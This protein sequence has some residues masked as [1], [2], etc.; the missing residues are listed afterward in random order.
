MLP[1]AWQVDESKVYNLDARLFCQFPHVVRCSR[2]E[3]RLLL[4]YRAVMVDGCSTSPRYRM[5][6]TRPRESLPARRTPDR[7]LSPFSLPRGSTSEFRDPGDYP[8][9]FLSSRIA[10]VFSALYR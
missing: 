10:V 2:D 7:L 9:H 8:S 1:H 5:N 6:Y 4:R 3:A